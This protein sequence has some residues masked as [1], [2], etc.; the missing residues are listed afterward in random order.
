MNRCGLTNQLASS[1]LKILEIAKDYEN[2]CEQLRSL[3]RSKFEKIRDLAREALDDITKTL[4]AL[5]CLNGIVKKL[6]FLLY[7]Y[8]KLGSVK[9]ENVIFDG[10]LCYRPQ[11]YND[12]LVYLFKL[13]VPRQN[14]T[15]TVTVLAGGY[16]TL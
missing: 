12:G 13:L 6:I 16:F 7:F 1:M 4:T 8:L 10:A 14:R 5:R 15:N 9:Y 3:T 11:I 2:F